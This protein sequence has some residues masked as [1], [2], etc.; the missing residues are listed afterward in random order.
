M[1][2]FKIR[3]QFLSSTY[4]D[5]YAASQD[6]YKNLHKKF[7]KKKV[8]YLEYQNC[9]YII[10]FSKCEFIELNPCENGI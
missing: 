9:S 5:L 4:I 1:S 6:D 2:K 10:D 7:S 3:I 8:E